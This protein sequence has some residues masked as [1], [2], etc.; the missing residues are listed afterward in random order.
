MARIRA[1]EGPWFL[2]VATYRWREHVGPGRDFHLGYRTEEE[3]RPWLASDPVDWLAE[4]LDPKERAGI[5]GEVR[6]E[7]AAA[8]AFAEDSP[9]PAAEELT[10]DVFKEERHAAASHRG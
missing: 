2:E 1:G 7:I 3:A 8:F 10:S 4:L 5:E 9:F 6:E